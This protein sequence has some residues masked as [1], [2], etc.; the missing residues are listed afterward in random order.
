LVLAWFLAGAAAALSMIFIGVG[1]SNAGVLLIAGVV[2]L[3]TTLVRIV[4]PAIGARTRW[5]AS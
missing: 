4:V 1:V 3:A 5:A 2:A